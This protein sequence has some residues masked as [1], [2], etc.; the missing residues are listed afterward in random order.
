MVSSAL[1]LSLS[2]THAH[3]G[4]GMG[5]LGSEGCWRRRTMGGESENYNGEESLHGA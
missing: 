4:S 2:Q 3:D 1:S 5:E